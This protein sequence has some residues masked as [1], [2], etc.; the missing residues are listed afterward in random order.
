[1]NLTDT[2]ASGAWRL[3]VPA[4]RAFLARLDET[5]LEELPLDG[6]RVPFTAGPRGVV[7]VLV[8]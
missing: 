3:G 7:T 4:T 2:A 6:D 5:P 1:V 8:K